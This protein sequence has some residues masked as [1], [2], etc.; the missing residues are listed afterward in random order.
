M[1]NCAAI[2]FPATAAVYAPLN[3]LPILYAHVRTY[4]YIYRIQKPRALNARVN[5]HVRM[6]VYRIGTYFVSGYGEACVHNELMKFDWKLTISVSYL[7]IH[8]HL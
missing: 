5:A 7:C 2:M 3:V 4:I 6:D 8:I 1:D